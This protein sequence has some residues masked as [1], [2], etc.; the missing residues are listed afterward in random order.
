M[1]VSEAIEF[2]KAYDQDEEILIAWWDRET[3]DHNDISVEEWNKM[4]KII[5]GFNHLLEDVHWAIDEAYAE[6]KAEVNV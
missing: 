2:L 1:K 3:T 4:L 6:V 5:D